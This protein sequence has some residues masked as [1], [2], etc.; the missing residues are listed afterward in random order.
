MVFANHLTSVGKAKDD[1]TEEAKKIIEQGASDTK[2]QRRDNITNLYHTIDAAMDNTAMRFAI[3]KEAAQSYAY[4]CMTRDE[5]IKKLEAFNTNKANHD[6][7]IETHKQYTGKL[8][9]VVSG[10]NRLHTDP[11]PA[12]QKTKAEA[13]TEAT[14]RALN[15]EILRATTVVSTIKPGSERHAARISKA[16]DDLIL[17][18][19][20][21]RD[22]IAQEATLKRAV[23]GAHRH[24]DVASMA[25]EAARK[26]HDKARVA[27]KAG[28]E[29]IVAY[30][31]ALGEEDILTRAYEH[32][33]LVWE[34]SEKVPEKGYAWVCKWL[35]EKVEELEKAG[36][37]DVD[38]AVR[39]AVEALGVEVEEEGHGQGDAGAEAEGVEGKKKK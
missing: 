38:V 20:Q 28:M 13:V 2:K 35:E 17:A 30:S 12:D 29:A 24:K 16:N 1:A 31:K 25:L 34:A 11:H 14:K 22:M 3:F 9:T 36:V 27:C 18:G 4:W 39:E 33:R 26:E 19:L 8:A 10:L 7:D 21:L 32:N 23:T 15:P 6:A 37:E 5:A